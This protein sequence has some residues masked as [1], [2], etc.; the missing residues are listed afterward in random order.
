LEFFRGGLHRARHEL[1]EESL[2]VKLLKSCFKLW[3]L[4]FSY[5]GPLLLATIGDVVIRVIRLLLVHAVQFNFVVVLESFL[6][7]FQSVVGFSDSFEMVGVD[8]AVYVWVVLLGQFKVNRFQLFIT[9]VAVDAQYLVVV[10]VVI[11]D[12]GFLGE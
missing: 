1:V 11:R 7:V 2:S 12:F 8:S 9:D 4:L 10:L 3:I 6:R 5:F